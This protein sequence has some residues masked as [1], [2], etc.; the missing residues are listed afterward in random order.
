MESHNTNSNITPL[1]RLGHKYGT[2]KCPQIKHCYTPFY[3]ELFNDK[4]ESIQKVL[5]VG[6]GNTRR[7]KHQLKVVSELGFKHVLQ[8]GASLRMWRDFFPNAR[9]FG[10]DIIPETMFTDERIH[11][12]LCDE[13]KE[14]DIVTLIK[15]IGSDVDMVID[16]ASH[17]VAD[18]VFLAKNLLP[19]LQK[20][21]T[22]VIEDVRHSQYIRKTLNESGRYEYTVPIIPRTWRGGQ[23]VVIRN[24]I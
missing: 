12:Y 23:I 16:D 14:E 22:Y 24:T 18:Q 17:H 2:D 6:I 7:N 21:V 11:T 3:Y 19:L 15:T 1:C 10:A 5:E 4:R 8:R 9:V 13:K 20:N